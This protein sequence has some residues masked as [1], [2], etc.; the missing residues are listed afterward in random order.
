MKKFLFISSI[1]LLGSYYSFSQNVGIGTTTPA[2]KL[3]VK[4][5]SI[6]TDSLYRIGGL[7][8]LSIPGTERIC[9]QAK[10]I[11]QYW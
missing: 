3:D 4:N 8:V 11:D 1:L 9:W 10:R 5:G 7:P 6:N 2:Y